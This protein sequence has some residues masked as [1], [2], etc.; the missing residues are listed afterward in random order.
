MLRRC[1]LVLFIVLGVSQS[2]DAQLRI[3]PRER[4]DSVTD[5]RLSSDS[6]VI[7]FE[8][9][10][11]VAETMNE[12][13]APRPFIFRFSNVG[14]KDIA[15][16]RLVST[17]SCLS[18]SVD[19]KSVAPGEKAEIKAIYNPK[20]H[21]GKF[22]RRI[23]VYTEGYEEPSAVLR[24]TVTVENGA[25]LSGLWPVQMG[26]IRLRRSEVSFDQK[27]KGV[28]KLRFINLSGRPMKLQCET[29]FL[30]ECLEFKTVPEVVPDGET[31]EI[32]ISYD[33]EQ[34]ERHNVMKVILKGLGISPSRSTLTVKL[35]P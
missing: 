11:I 18:A 29:A 17:C 27:K 34:P 30:P 22:E 6:S 16:S 31:G 15:I 9:K 14:T 35:E 26:T 25:D 28:E 21:P 23:F 10:H 2:I 4:I 5:P 24:L 33:P 8:T 19:R 7:C 3:I 20:G 32:V 1:I 13:D 12:D